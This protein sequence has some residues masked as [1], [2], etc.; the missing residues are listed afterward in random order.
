MGNEPLQAVV[1]DLDGVLVES[2]HLWEENWARF[3]E[4]HGTPWTADDTASVQGMSAPEWARYLWRHTGRPGTAEET[5]HDVVGGMVA[6]FEN[7]RVDLLPGAERLVSSISGRYPIA[8]ASSAPRRLIDAVLRGH[9][10]ADRFTTTV[11]SAEVPRGKPH[12]DVYAEAARRLGLSGAQCAAVEDSSNGIRSAHAAGMT[13]VA[14]PNPVY[15]PASDALALTTARAQDLGEVGE[16][17]LK[18]LA[19][20][21]AEGHS[22]GRGDGAHPANGRP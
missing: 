11:S 16:H 17:L 13:V 3:A 9:G 10:L 12:P 5:E 2:E 18:L 7:G 22:P 15:P 4:R 8:L 1:F 21:P 14:L 6:D 20:P 19:P